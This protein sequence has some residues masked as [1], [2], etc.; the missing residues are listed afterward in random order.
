[1]PVLSKFGSAVGVGAEIGV[2]ATAGEPVS[3]ELAVAVA[4]APAA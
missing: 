1:L 2:P 3:A 4:D